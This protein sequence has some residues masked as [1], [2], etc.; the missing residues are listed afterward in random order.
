L[1]TLQRLYKIF[2]CTLPI[3]INH[4]VSREELH[5]HIEERGD[6]FLKPFFY[7]LDDPVGGLKKNST[8]SIFHFPNNKNMKMEL[9]YFILFFIVQKK[10]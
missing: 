1:F 3:V 9:L 10:G 5:Y 6:F 2:F 7:G 4:R 8:L